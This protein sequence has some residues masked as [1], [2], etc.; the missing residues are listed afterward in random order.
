MTRE[1]LFGATKQF[2]SVGTWFALRYKMSPDLF[3]Y[4]SVL[5]Q[6]TFNM[7]GPNGTI[8]TQDRRPY[9]DRPIYGRKRIYS[10]RCNRSR[11]LTA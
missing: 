8:A 11:L 5:A 10:W 4:L 7:Y 6:D 1:R 9:T 2:A 3:R